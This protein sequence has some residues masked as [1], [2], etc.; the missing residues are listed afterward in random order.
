MS[1]YALHVHPLIGAVYVSRSRSDLG[2]NLGRRG[3]LA[4]PGCR[5]Q[6]PQLLGLLHLQPVL[7]PGRADR[8]LPRPGRHGGRRGPR[9]ADPGLAL[10]PEGVV[11]P[12][13]AVSASRPGRLLENKGRRLGADAQGPV[14]ATEQSPQ[15]SARASGL[16]PSLSHSGVC[17]TASTDTGSRDELNRRVRQTSFGTDWEA[18]PLSKLSTATTVRQDSR[19]ESRATCSSPK[20]GRG[21]C[22]ACAC[23]SPLC[24]RSRFRSGRRLSR[25]AVKIDCARTGGT[26]RPN[27]ALVYRLVPLKS[28]V[29]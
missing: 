21:A 24:P 28:P 18:P 5:P 2:D 8:G 9:R 17:A 26:V 13:R 11:Q 29:R 3:L 19:P 4:G 10:K 23:A 12:E 16:A 6:G 22:F 25:K 20:A 15:W 1:C 14:R 27:Y 7:L